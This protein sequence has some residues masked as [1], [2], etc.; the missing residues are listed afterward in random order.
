MTSDPRRLFL[1][2]QNRAARLVTLPQESHPMSTAAHF[3]SLAL[4]IMEPPSV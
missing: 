3:L 4:S 1:L 2:M